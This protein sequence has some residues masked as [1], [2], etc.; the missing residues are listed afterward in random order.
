MKSEDVFK[1]IKTLENIWE[2]KPE[3]A[4]DVIAMH[5]NATKLW[6]SRNKAEEEK[7]RK[8]ANVFIGACIAANRLGISDIP[9]IIENRLVEL[10]KLAKEK[11]Y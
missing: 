1:R 3:L 5:E 11:K 9:K 7:Q 6:L 2:V 4:I 8:L 10:E